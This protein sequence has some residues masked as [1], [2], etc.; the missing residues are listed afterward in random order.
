MIISHLGTV[1]KWY[2]LCQ[3]TVSCWLWMKIRYPCQYFWIYSSLQYCYL[4]ASGV[5]VTADPSRSCLQVGPIFLF[6]GR[7][8]W[9][10]ALL[11]QGGSQ[12][13]PS[14]SSHTSCPICAWANSRKY[15]FQCVPHTNSTQLHIYFCLFRSNWCSPVTYPESQG[16]WGIDMHKVPE[17][18]PP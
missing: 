4:C 1:W 14:A 18:E 8:H 6:L 17:N 13:D 5:D 3:L 15:R 7:W 2:L 11:L 12:V 10:V 16:D 9:G